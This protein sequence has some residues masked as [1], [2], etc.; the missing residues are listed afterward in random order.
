[1]PCILLTGNLFPLLI[2]LSVVTHLNGDI[3]VASSFLSSQIHSKLYDLLVGLTT[4]K[5]LKQIF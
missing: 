1:M 4:P 2:R 5:V 3:F